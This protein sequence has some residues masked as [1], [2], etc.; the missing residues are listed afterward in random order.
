LAG[1][2]PRPLE[3][4][5]ERVARLEQRAGFLGAFLVVVGFVELELLAQSLLH[6]VERVGE[7]RGAAELE[8]ALAMRMHRRGEV[9]LERDRVLVDA[10]DRQHDVHVEELIEIERHLMGDGVAG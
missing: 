1:A 7:P 3:V 10:A 4:G 8:R 5:A 6:F 2:A 9:A